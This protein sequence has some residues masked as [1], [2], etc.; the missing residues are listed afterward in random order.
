MATGKLYLHSVTCATGIEWV[1]HADD[2]HHQKKYTFEL[3]SA[4]SAAIGRAF[5]SNSQQDCYFRQV[6][7]KYSLAKPYPSTRT[8][9]VWL[10][11]YSSFCK[12]GMQLSRRL[13]N[14]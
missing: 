2:V 6:A 7:I 3:L 1:V 5:Y 9:K 10:Q 12:V 13:H 14:C 4:N 11:G 8:T